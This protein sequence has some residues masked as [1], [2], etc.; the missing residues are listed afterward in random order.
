MLLPSFVYCHKAYIFLV[1]C[2]V[3]SHIFHF[4]GSG[5][6]PLFTSRKHFQAGLVLQYEANI[7]Q[8]YQVLLLQ[9]PFHEH[10]V[11]KHY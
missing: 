7:S 11:Y 3:S 4:L 6:N 8:T 1:L 10:Q 2:S 9:S 5:G